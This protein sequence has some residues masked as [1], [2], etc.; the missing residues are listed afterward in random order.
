MYICTRYPTFL[1]PI[2]LPR[3]T[4][5][6]SLPSLNPGRLNYV[7]Y[8]NAF[9]HPLTSCYVQTMEGTPAEDQRAVKEKS[10]DIYSSDFPCQVTMAG[11][12]LN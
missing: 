12:L 4:L 6:A 8:S 2:P 1:F 3:P 9:P 10:Q 5:H 7:N 11:H